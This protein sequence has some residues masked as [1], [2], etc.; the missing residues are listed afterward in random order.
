VRAKFLYCPACGKGHRFQVVQCEKCGYGK[1]APLG[2]ANPEVEAASVV[3]LAA[4]EPNPLP[5]EIPEDLF[6]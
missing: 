3:L 5:S 4:D 1:P 6:E 2:D